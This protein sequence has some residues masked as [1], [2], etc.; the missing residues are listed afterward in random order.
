MKR[1]GKKSKKGVD[2][3]KISCYPII[4]FGGVNIYIKKVRHDDFIGV[5][6]P[7]PDEDP[8]PWNKKKDTD[9][10]LDLFKDYKPPLPFWKRVL[11]RL[12]RKPRG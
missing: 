10:Q 9:Q 7:Y 5:Y 8:T 6:H 3:S 2:K 4:P 1:Q 12:L 11:N